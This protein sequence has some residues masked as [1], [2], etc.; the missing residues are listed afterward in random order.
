MSHHP[1]SPSFSLELIPKTKKLKIKTVSLICSTLSYFYKAW[2]A[3]DK[4]TKSHMWAL[5]ELLWWEAKLITYASEANDDMRRVQACLD[6]PLIINVVH[7]SD[8]S[9]G[10]WVCTTRHMYMCE[11]QLFFVPKWKM[12]RRFMIYWHKTL[13]LSYRLTGQSL[14]LTHRHAV[15]LLYFTLP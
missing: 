8:M 11:L 12:W 6:P 5:R 14:T 7:L 2:W 1:D 4:E 9:Y 13:K 3:E 15:N 10:T